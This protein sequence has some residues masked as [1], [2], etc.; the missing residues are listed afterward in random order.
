MQDTCKLYADCLQDVKIIIFISKFYQN[1]QIYS[2]E[3]KNML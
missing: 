3:H 1:G 2:I